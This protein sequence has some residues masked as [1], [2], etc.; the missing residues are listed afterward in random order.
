[1]AKGN[2]SLLPKI[3]R[4]V[5]EQDENPLYE[6]IGASALDN[7][8]TG[9]KYLATTIWDWFIPVLPDLVGYGAVATGALVIVSTMAGRGV[10]KP[11]GYF[12]GI[13]VVA[14][15]ILEAN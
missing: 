4:W 12:G 6:R 10:V 11:L 13:A 8:I 9:V 15:C 7:I 2:E 5:F 3:G 14:V 1:M